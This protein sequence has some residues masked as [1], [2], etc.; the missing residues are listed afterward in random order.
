MTTGQPDIYM[1]FSLGYLNVYSLRAFTTD[2]VQKTNGQTS[3][4]LL[5]QIYQASQKG[6]T[7]TSLR[8]ICL[9][10]DGDRIC[11]HIQVKHNDCAT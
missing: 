6:A 10:R 2:C 9:T 8:G 4:E 5:F 1:H 11:P 7:T 3:V